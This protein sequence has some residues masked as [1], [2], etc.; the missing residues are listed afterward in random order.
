MCLGAYETRLRRGVD[1]PAALDSQLNLHAGLPSSQIMFT[2][3]FYV[4]SYIVYLLPIQIIYL[5]ENKCLL[6]EAFDAGTIWALLAPASPYG[7]S[8]CW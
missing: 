1:L 6:L 7:L 3:V 5:L 2:Y 4:I 8:H